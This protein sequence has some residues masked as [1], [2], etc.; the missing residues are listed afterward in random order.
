MFG[1]LATSGV[2][3][4]Q[5]GAQPY[6]PGAV[7]AY[8]DSVTVQWLGTAPNCGSIV[9]PKQPKGLPNGSNPGGNALYRKT[10]SGWSYVTASGTVKN[11]WY[12]SWSFSS[13]YKAVNGPRKVVH[14]T[15]INWTCGIFAIT[16]R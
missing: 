13:G 3:S 1:L 15:P 16:T 8:K 11:G 2:A 4:A 6:P 10:I 9:R 5:T 12:Q 14:T 7:R